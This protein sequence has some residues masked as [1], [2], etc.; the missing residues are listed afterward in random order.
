MRSLVA[1][2]ALISFVPS[3]GQ[4]GETGIGRVSLQV[5]PF[6]LLERDTVLP[7]TGKTVQSETNAVVGAAFVAGL[8][9]NAAGGLWLGLDL[10]P[11]MLNPTRDWSVLV[12]GRAVGGYSSERFSIGATI[13]SGRLYGTFPLGV[14]LAARI[15]SLRGLYGRARIAFNL[16]QGWFQVPFSG[17]LELNVPVTPSVK[18]HLDLTYVYIGLNFA[19]GIQ[20][21]LAGDGGPGSHIL[22]AGAGVIWNAE[23]VGPALTAGYE[24]R[25]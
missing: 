3:A 23:P 14:G 24:Y 20:Y 16:F 10:S 13:E 22:I 1:L 6:V 8:E 19:G 11:L 18:L 12:L 7:L 5:Q 15:G 2:V 17:Q 25:W 9:F 21:L 4:A